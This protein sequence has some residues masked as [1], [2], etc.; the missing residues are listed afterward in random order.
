M[1]SFSF[2]R[3]ICQYVEVRR[4]TT[5]NSGIW[6][7]IQ[8]G[9]ALI[10]VAV[11]VWDPAFDDSLVSKVT[12]GSGRTEVYDLT[13][14]RL[15]ALWATSPLTRGSKDLVIPEEALLAFV[16]GKRNPHG[17]LKIARRLR[18]DNSGWNTSFAILRNAD[19]CWEMSA[20]LFMAW[21]G[22]YVRPTSARDRYPTRNLSCNVIKDRNGK[23][24]FLPCWHDTLLLRARKS[25]QGNQDEFRDSLCSNIPRW[26]TGIYEPVLCVSARVFSNPDIERRCIFAFNRLD[27]RS[28]YSKDFIV[29]WDSPLPKD[30]LSTLSVAERYLDNSFEVRPSFSFSSPVSSNAENGTRVNNSKWSRSHP[31][32]ILKFDDVRKEYDSMWQDLELILKPDRNRDSQTP[33]TASTESPTATPVLANQE[34]PST[35]P[36]IE[37]QMLSPASEGNQRDTPEARSQH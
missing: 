14:V 11:W 35:P 13:D 20:G 4:L 5:R 37:L 24:H 22:H 32:S 27:A 33:S 8:G 17:M 36:E 18:Q 31:S 3:Y 25:Y 12:A 16:P 10:R 26:S 23:F 2:E 6:L 28:P 30:L 15:I 29:G 9:L 1:H 21:V 34:Q 19:C 7:S